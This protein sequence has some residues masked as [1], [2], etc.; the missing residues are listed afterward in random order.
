MIEITAKLIRGPVYFSGEVI[1]CLVSF[2]NPPNPIHQISQSH[3][4]IF[5]SLAWA[6]AQVHCQCSTNSKIVFSEKLN[7]TAQLAAINANTT[8][9]PW[10]QDNGHVVLNTKPKILFCDLRLSPG[11]SKTFL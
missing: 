11:E 10:Q 1:E 6:S 2:S 3:S 5:E 7:M 4:D 9:A 8:F